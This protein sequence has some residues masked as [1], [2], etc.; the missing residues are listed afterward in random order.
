MLFYLKIWF[1][2]GPRNSRTFYP[3][4]RLFTIGKNIAKFRIRGIFPRL[5][6]IFDEI[7]L[8]IQIKE[9]FLGHTLLPH[10]SRYNIR[11]SL[12]ERNYREL[13]GLKLT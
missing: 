11:G 7:R 9:L 3:R 5:F 4:I 13:R 12:A 8:K 2:G 10:I 6:A 1:T